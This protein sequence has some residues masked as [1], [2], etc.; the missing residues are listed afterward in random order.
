MEEVKVLNIDTNKAQ[1]SVKDVRKELKAVQDSMVGL[2][3][4]SSAFLEAANKAGELKHQL[5]EIQRATRGASADFGDIIGNV[6]QIGAGIAGG[7][8]AAQGA[9]QLFGVESEAVVQSMAKLQGI[10]AIVQGLSSMDAAIKGMKTLGTTIKVGLDAAQVGLS[11]VKKAI[12]ATGIGLLVVAVGT[13][14]AYWEDIAKWVKKSGDNLRDFKREQDSVNKN[15]SRQAELARAAG[16][17]QEEVLN[18]EKQE[19]E[20]LLALSKEEFKRLQE[21]KNLGKKLSKEEQNRYDELIKLNDEYSYKLQLNEIKLTKLKSDEEEKQTQKESKEL[22]KQLEERRKKALE[23]FSIEEQLRLDIASLKDMKGGKSNLPEQPELPEEVEEEDE[24]YFELLNSYLNYI[25]QKKLA[26]MDYLE[27]VENAKE[28]EKKYIDNLEAEGVITHEMAEKQKAEIS[29][30]YAKK[31]TAYE[32]KATLQLAS[33]LSSILNSI[34]SMQDT[35]DREGFERS[36][37][38]QTAAA[39]INML[40]GIT[41]AL[42]GLFTTKSGPWDVALAAMQAATIAASG[43]ANIA[44]IQKQQYNSPSSVSATPSA[45]A[46]SATIMPPTQFSQAVQG[47]ELESKI[48]DTKVYV[49][50]TDI[51]N[52]QN[53]VNI[54]ETENR[55]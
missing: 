19:L 3:E 47:V 52:T 15:Y 23:E 26:D 41:S 38:M 39:T 43:T 24:R 49:T 4:G 18:I 1:K 54:Q 33:G 30:H 2:E 17:S 22:E 12:A 8:G 35:N 21:K 29:E 20:T 37:K 42:S 46:I 32:L 10:M 34:A 6:T 51:S 55:Y 28:E 16:K 11:G 9:M 25:D 36:K 53:K 45:S 13:L 27:S 44:Q 14:A 31:K 50:E 40:V 7:F 5:D 48:S